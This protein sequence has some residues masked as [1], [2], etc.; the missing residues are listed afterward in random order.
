MSL[1]AA[2]AFLHH[3]LLSNRA[4]LLQGDAYTD[5]W[6]SAIRHTPKLARRMDDS[7]M[8]LVA[9]LYP[10]KTHVLYW[11]RHAT[12]HCNTLPHEFLFSGLDR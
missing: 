8:S 9:E 6:R 12:V 4:E 10:D 1:W 7:T 2:V 3:L 11:P 5:A